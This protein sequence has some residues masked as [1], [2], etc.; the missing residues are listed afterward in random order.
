MSTFSKIEEHKKVCEAN[1]QYSYKYDAYGC[2]NC[3]IFFEKK[4]EDEECEF[5]PQRPEKFLHS[6]L[7]DQH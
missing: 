4:C 2:A 1:I 3:G 6:S 7:N 5:C